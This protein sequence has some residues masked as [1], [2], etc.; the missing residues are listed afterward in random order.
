M[1][2]RSPPTTGPF[3]IDACAALVLS[4][5]PLLDSSRV[6]IPDDEVGL[7]FRGRL[8]VVRNAYAERGLEA[9]DEL[10]LLLNRS[11][12]SQSLVLLPGA[13]GAHVSISNQ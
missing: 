5:Q 6:V 1:R 10:L 7:S 11:D 4:S 3:L 13:P 12:R 2:S 8:R 9:L